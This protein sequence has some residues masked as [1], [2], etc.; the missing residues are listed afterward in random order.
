MSDALEKAGYSNVS[1]AARADISVTAR[2]DVVQER[3]DRQ[4]Q[5]TFA[6]RNYSIDVSGEARTGDVVSMPPPST[7]SF[8]PQVGAERANERSRIVAADVIDRIKEFVQR[9]RGG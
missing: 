6:V 4:F 3:V 2:A 1:T 5:T 7:V 9:K 8:D